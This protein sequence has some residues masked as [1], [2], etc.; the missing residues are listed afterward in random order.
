MNVCVYI[1]L[2]VSEGTAHS[3]HTHT[4]THTLRPTQTPPP[5]SRPNFTVLQRKNWHRSLHS[6]TWSHDS[7]SRTRRL[8]SFYTHLNSTVGRAQDKKNKQSLIDGVRPFFSEVLFP[9]PGY[10][11]LSSLILF[12]FSV[13]AHL[14]ASS[15]H[16][17]HLHLA[18][19]LYF[20]AGFS[21]SLLG[22]CSLHWAPSS[23]ALY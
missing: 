6:T 2:C 3:T 4:H 9:L 18:K 13:W 14:S 22:I 17:L 23:C 15:L 11:L 1:C 21:A 7:Q 20:K 5:A 16:H 19:L 12:P 8:M 10:A